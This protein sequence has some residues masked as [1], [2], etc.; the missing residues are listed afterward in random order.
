MS[1]CFIIGSVRQVLAPLVLLCLLVASCADSTDYSGQPIVFVS[2]DGFDDNISVVNP[3]GSDRVQVTDAEGAAADPVW[4]PDGTRIAFVKLGTDGNREIRLM[5]A[6]GS[7]QTT[8]CDES[9]CSPAPGLDLAWSPDGSRI[10]FTSLLDGAEEIYAMNIDGSG[11]I[12]LTEGPPPS[13]RPVVNGQP[14]WSPDGSAIAFM[15]DQ[16]GDAD[17]YTMNPDGSEVTKLTDE[18]W[19]DY[20][21]AW[22]PDSSRIA[23]ASGFRGDI[24]V[25]NADGTNRSRLTYDGLNSHPNWSPDGTRLIY[26][27]Q[28]PEGHFELLIMNL[29]QSDSNVL[30]TGTDP[31]W[32]VG[33]QDQ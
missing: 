33:S 19:D 15:S 20:Q 5:N 18:T 8:L 27:S 23:F 9:T 12:R 10:V 21:P 2:S 31:N 29:D 25:M 28:N 32:H 11:L 22:S 30:T 4:S 1:F 3:D 13:E 14:D 6:D 17:I 26:Q 16:E 7:E 24:F